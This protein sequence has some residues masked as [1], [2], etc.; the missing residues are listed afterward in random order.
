MTETSLSR[1]EFV[2][3]GGATAAAGALASQLPAAGRPLDEIRV[4]LV[5]CGG[6]GRGAAVN[7]LESSSGVKL[8]AIA[9]AFERKVHEA[10]K[11]FARTKVKDHVELDDDSCFWGL[12]A[13]KQVIHH[14]KVDLVI[15]ATPPAFRP[16]HLAEIVKA[17]K[18][19]FIEKPCCVDPTGY[20]SVLASAAE[21]RAN[22]TA[23]V[24]GTLFRRAKNY[25]EGIAA[26]HEGAI[27]DILFAQAR[28][29]S[30]G[31]WYRKREP[32]MTDAEYQINNW[33][34]FVWLSGDQIVEQA[35]HNLDAINW[36]MGGPPSRAYGA[37]GQRNRPADSEI[38]DNM[39]IDYEYPNGATLSF[40]CRQ[41]AGKGMVMN[42]IVGTKGVAVIMPFGKATLTSHDGKQIFQ[43]RYGKNAYVTEH[44]DL[45][46]SI[47]AG[48]P[49][50]EAEVLANSSLTAVMG[51]LAG[52]SG[53]E[54]TW[55][56]VTE[57]SHLDLMPEKLTMQSEMPKR[58]VAVPGRYRLG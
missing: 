13:Y 19:A 34:H 4:G 14:P 24:T 43:S 23:I 42:R 21:A 53:Q 33:Y 51:R 41:Q 45:I 31:I 6:R 9:D 26:I 49:I 5:G 38:Y 11:V 7:S 22:G 47:R 56:F 2:K 36:V 46:A 3:L 35:V 58:E 52:Y 1:R 18:H 8:V 39:E 50:V 32:G 54:V 48:T 27:G 37:G 25:V 15:D 10:R 28:Y 55:D 57:K 29:C 16:S 40:M 12:D 20:H 17:K 30:G 44:T